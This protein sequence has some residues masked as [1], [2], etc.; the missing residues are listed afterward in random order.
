MRI[1]TLLITVFFALGLLTTPQ[2]IQAQKDGEAQ[3]VIFDTQN[4]PTL[5]F[6]AKNEK[7]GCCGFFVSYTVMDNEEEALAI[8]I[9]HVHRQGWGAITFPERGWLYIA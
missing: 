2:T 5:Q 3:A 7:L 8:R 6:A 9:D 4:R 1:N